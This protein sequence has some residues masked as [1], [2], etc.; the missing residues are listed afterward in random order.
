MAKPAMVVVVGES[1]APV[2]FSLTLISGA[3][4]GLKSKAWVEKQSCFPT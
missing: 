2:S 4:L 1:I 3:K